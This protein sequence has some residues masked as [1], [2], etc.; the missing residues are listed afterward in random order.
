MKARKMCYQKT[1]RFHIKQLGQKTL[2]YDE[3]NA[4]ESFQHSKKE[5]GKTPQTR[6]T[7]R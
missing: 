1:S 4:K 5:Q 3:N 2:G 6:K 7:Q